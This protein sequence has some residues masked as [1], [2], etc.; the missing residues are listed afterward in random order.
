[1]LLLGGIRDARC[2]QGGYRTQV[3]LLGEIRD[4]GGAIRPN[5]NINTGPKC[6]YWGDYGSEVLLLGEIW[7]PGGA[8]SPRITSI[9][10]M[11]PLY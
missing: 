4:L 1:M 8:I 3:V 7:D 6:C 9:P 2:Y 5:I 10:K 11:D